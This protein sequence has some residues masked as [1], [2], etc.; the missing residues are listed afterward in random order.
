MKKYSALALL[1]LNSCSSMQP[2]VE[3]LQNAKTCE[4]WKQDTLGIRHAAEVKE[5]M[6]KQLISCWVWGMFLCSYNEYTFAAGSSEIESSVLG[7]VGELKG[8]SLSLH[9]T[10]S[11]VK[12]FEIKNG[13]ADYMIKNI[14][15]P[16]HAS[17]VE[18]N[19]KCTVRQAALGLVALIGF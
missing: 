10:G 7:K 11:T 3:E 14:V 5:E 12:P 6:S 16:E 18:F 15:G 19:E 13:R 9:L 4:V 17:S 1:L 2:N 8:N